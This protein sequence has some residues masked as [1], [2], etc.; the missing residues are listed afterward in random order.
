MSTAKPLL[1]TSRVQAVLVPKSRF[2]A[3]EFAVEHVAEMGFITYKVDESA[4]FYRFRQS[5]PDRKTPV[6]RTIPVGKN[7]TMLVIEFHT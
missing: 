7:G 4:K 2:L 3:L 5:E 1:G 6:K